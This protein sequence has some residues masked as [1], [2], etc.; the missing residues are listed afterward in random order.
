MKTKSIK[1]TTETVKTEETIDYLQDEITSATEMQKN[2]S[3]F[4]ELTEKP[5]LAAIVGCAMWTKP[6]TDK[7]TGETF[8]DFILGLKV[9]PH[10]DS[11]NPKILTIRAF[12]RLDQK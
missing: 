2:N 6:F 10:S 9:I 3:L 5:V 11:E 12:K 7:K 1:K 8:N 4:L